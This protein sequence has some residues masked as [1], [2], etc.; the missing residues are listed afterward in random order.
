MSKYKGKYEKCRKCIHVS[1]VG[2][3]LVFVK[4]E[5]PNPNKRGNSDFKTV[6]K[7]D[8]EECKNY[9]QGHKNNSRL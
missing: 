6:F 7:Q 2:M 8:C 5:C 1:D 3:V 9:K 4:P